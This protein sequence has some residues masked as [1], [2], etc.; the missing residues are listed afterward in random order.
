M[1]F[2]Y[3]QQAI[4]YLRKST[5]IN[6]DLTEAYYWLGIA[7]FKIGNFDEAIIFLKQQSN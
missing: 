6:P 3:E 4:V 5:G 7:L 1:K 2:E